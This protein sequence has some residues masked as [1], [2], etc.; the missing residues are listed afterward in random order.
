MVE[1]VDGDGRING[2]AAPNHL[3]GGDF[4]DILVGGTPLISLP[5]SKTANSDD[6]LEGRGGND[7]LSGEGGN[8]LV[9]GGDGNDSAQRWGR[10][11]HRAGRQR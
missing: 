5:P 6:V 2:T 9:N 10:A 8:D 7:R 4:D 3:R 1:N 11:G